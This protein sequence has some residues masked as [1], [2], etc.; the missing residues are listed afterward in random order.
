MS[1][2][3]RRTDRALPK[4]ESTRD[5]I[6]KKLPWLLGGGFRI[7]RFRFPDLTGKN[8]AISTP[9]RL[10]GLLA[11][12]IFSF[13]LMMGGIYLWI[14]DQ[15]ALGAD[16]RGNAVWLYPGIHDAFIIESIVAAAI[17]F[18]GAGGF[19]V[20]YESTKHATNPPY[21]WKLLALG[22]MMGLLS[23]VAIQRIIDLKS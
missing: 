17:I 18:I 5:K 15:I 8:I 19:Y 2:T 7:P 9:P 4:I 6:G 12:Y 14:R 21:A 11:T 13:W 22:L 16:Q 23:F 1:K 20:M 3:A 10:L